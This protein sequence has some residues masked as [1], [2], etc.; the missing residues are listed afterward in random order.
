M[1][2]TF[3]LCLGCGRTSDEIA[4]WSSD[5]DQRRHAIWDLLPERIDTLGIAITRL[6]WPHG[7]IAEFVAE[8]LQQKSGTWVLGCHG[9]VAEFNCAHDKHAA[10]LLP[11]IL[12]AR[13]QI[14]VHCGW[15]L[16]SMSERCVCE[17]I[18]Y[19]AAIAPFFLL[20]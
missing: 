14:A 11:V 2:A 8:S 1:D 6:P 5:G 19:E 4:E 17:L 7:R 10:F 9:A 3:G 18:E 16:T 20:S 12:S 15:Q 13:S